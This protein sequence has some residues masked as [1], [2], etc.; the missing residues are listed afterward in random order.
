MA[1][2]STIYAQSSEKRKFKLNQINDI[3]YNHFVFDAEFSNLFLNHNFLLNTEPRMAK[4]SVEK[5]A[6]CPK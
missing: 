6:N 1:S 2:R 3:P 5:N 4:K